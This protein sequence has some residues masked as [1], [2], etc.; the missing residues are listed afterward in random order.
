MLSFIKSVVRSVAERIIQRFFIWMNVRRCSCRVKKADKVDR[1]CYY[2][3]PQYGLCQKS[4]PTAGEFVGHVFYYRWVGITIPQNLHS[5][6]MFTKNKQ[7]IS[8]LGFTADFICFLGR[9]ATTAFGYNMFFYYE[10]VLKAWP[11]NPSF[12]YAF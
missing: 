6:P 5:C 11:T 3:P 9:I 1:Q 7:D 8:L 2:R 12:A 10:N 4:S